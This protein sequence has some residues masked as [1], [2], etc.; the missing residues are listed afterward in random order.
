MKSPNP[1]EPPPPSLEDGD[2]VVDEQDSQD[3]STS[4][5]RDDA[6]PDEHVTLRQHPYVW[7][8]V[9]VTQ[10][11]LTAIMFGW[12][13]LVPILRA[14][15]LTYTPTELSQIFTAGAVGNYLATLPFGLLLDWYGPKTTGIVASLL[16]GLGLFLC[17]FNDVFWCFVFGF[18]LVG[19]ARP[20]IQMPTLHLANLF[21][22]GSGGAVYM[23]AQAAAFDAGTAIFALFHT[24][25]FSF[26]IPSKTMFLVYIIV[27]MWTL[28]TAICV[29][30]NETIAK[31]EA[32]MSSDASASASPTIGSPYFSPKDRKALASERRRQV[33]VQQQSQSTRLRSQVNAPLSVVLS[34]V[35]FYAL[36]TW[37]SI[38]IYKLN[39]IVA[40]INDQL[41]RHFDSATA[42]QLIDI[43]GAMLP[44]G[45]VVLPIVATMLHTQP[46]VALQVANVV[47]LIYGGVMTYLPHVY[48]LQIL[49][50][51]PA[52][53][54]SRQLV[55]ST[56]FHTI[57]Q[58]F[59]FANYGV[60]LGLTNA[61]ASLVQTLQTPMV[62]WSETVLGSYFWS[63]FTLW[64]VTIPLFVSVLYSDP[65]WR[66]GMKRSNRNKRSASQQGGRAKMQDNG[67]N[68]V[69][70]NEG[71]SLL[72]S[73]SAGE[74]QDAE[75][76][77]TQV[78]KSTAGS[79]TFQNI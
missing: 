24:F 73:A 45:F 67:D 34:H 23:S 35:A 31:E 54:T 18:G 66:P 39:Y 74:F 40:T 64:V 37:V 79:S 6:V 22:H 10:T 25:Y 20:G 49:V 51:F 41:I 47:G 28:M 77:T 44:F 75:D 60:L 9:G 58:V 65:T 15:G 68:G 57:G 78:S 48:W 69:I 19:L 30:P 50:V 21:G 43:L 32:P 76:N 29:W 55:Y 61:I 42:N 3:Q 56:L 27:P 52:V 16:Y 62:Y 11:F 33:Q 14:E 53:A 63:N 72:F 2:S 70:V 46:M 4:S 59:G 12:A 1:N 71:T 13:S 36:A 17:S 8:A 7:A 38:H 5:S 26:G